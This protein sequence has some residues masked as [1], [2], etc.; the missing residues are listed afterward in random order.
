MNTVRL[1]AKRARLRQLIHEF[2][3]VWEEVDRREVACFGSSSAPEMGVLIR[4][5][6]G[7]HERW[8]RPEDLGRKPEK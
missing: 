8:T 4:S 3:P 7:K 5:L 1:K 6:N 2:G